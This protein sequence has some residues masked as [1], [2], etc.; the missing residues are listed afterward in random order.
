MNG[1]RKPSAWNMFV[2]KIYHEGHNK[3]KSYSFKQALK[4]SSRRK[5]EMGTSSTSFASSKKSR[6][7]CMKSCKKACRKHRGRG[8]KRRR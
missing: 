2:K 3:N 8:T 6:R 5:S 1:G 4:D 7:A